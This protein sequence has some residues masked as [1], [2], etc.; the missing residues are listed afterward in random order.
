[1]EPS[2]PNRN[3]IGRTVRNARCVNSRWNPTV[4]PAIVTRY[5]PTR[6]PTFTHEKPQTKDS[7]IAITRPAT[8]TV[9]PTNVATHETTRRARL[10]R[11]SVGAAGVVVWSERWG[12]R[13]VDE[14]GKLSSWLRE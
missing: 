5:I 2:T 13:E 7:T 12:R 11:G 4:I 1:M 3:W 9:S 14:D 6:M 8:G 10:N